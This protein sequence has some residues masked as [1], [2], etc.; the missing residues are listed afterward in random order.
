MCALT[1]RAGAEDVTVWIGMGA[2]QEGEP[3]GIYQAS[4]NPETGE[5]KTP[6]LAA[7]IDTPEFLALRPDGRC[8]YA[9]CRLSNGSGGVAAFGIDPKDH[10]LRLMNT[11]PI[12]SGSSCHVAVDP[13]S[14][15]LYSAQYGDGS[16][17]VFPLAED[18]SI[19]PRSALVKHTG[20]GPNP[21]RQEAPHPHSVNPAPEDNF[22]LVPDLGTDEIVIYR[23]DPSAGSIERHGQGKSPPGAGP[24]HMTFDPHGK[25]V[26]VANELGLS[27]SVFKF[28]ATDGT[29]EAIQTVSTLPEEPHDPS[30]NCSEIRMHPSGRY[31]Y[32]ANR[33]HNSISAFAVD[34]QSGKLSFI[35]H[36]SVQ[37]KH[38]RNFNLDPEG[39]WLLAAARD[40]NSISVIKIDPDSGVLD[41]TGKKVTSPAPICILFQER[42]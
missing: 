21:A 10:S 40:S 36:E 19:Q 12:G 16:I 6:E 37:G 15:C 26:Y 29:L 24:R 11:Q 2:P 23:T 34:S 31:L 28:N 7:E 1:E 25:Y 27:I 41:N 42:H 30:Y 4:F 22:L 5:L 33:G 14:R 20:K 38:P 3:R 18:G 9:A 8:L 32:V 13:S 39:K 35:E 17:A